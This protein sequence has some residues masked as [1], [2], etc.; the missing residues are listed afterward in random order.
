MTFQY[1]FLVEGK[2]ERCR[3]LAS[4]PGQL[5]SQRPIMEYEFVL[6]LEERDLTG[7]QVE[8]VGDQRLVQRSRGGV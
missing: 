4:S 5:L 6:S 2:D 7:G 3:R 8:N 1:L